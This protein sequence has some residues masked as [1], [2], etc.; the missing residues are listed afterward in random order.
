MLE[1]LC[2]TGRR[3]LLLFH[4]FLQAIFLVAKLREF[5]LQLRTILEKFDE[6]FVLIVLL[7]RHLEYRCTTCHNRPLYIILADSARP[8]YGPNDDIVDG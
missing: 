6:F 4:S 7:V 3:A 2:N 8:A 5:L 1:L